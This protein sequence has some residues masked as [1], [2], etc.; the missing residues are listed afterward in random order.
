MVSSSLDQNIKKAFQKD[1]RLT[2]SECSFENHR[3]DEKF[4]YSDT[5]IPNEKI[6][7]MFPKCK[8]RNDQCQY[9]TFRKK[10]QDFSRPTNLTS[11]ESSLTNS[12][13]DK[14]ANSNNNNS[15][16]NNKSLTKIQ[17]PDHKNQQHSHNDKFMERHVKNFGIKMEKNHDYVETNPFRTGNNNQ[18]FC[19]P[20]DT[21]Y[22]N[23]NS[24]LA[25]S[26][27]NRVMDRHHYPPMNDLDYQSA[28]EDRNYFF[29]P[30]EIEHNPYMIHSIG[31]SRKSVH[32]TILNTSP[33]A[34]PLAL[35]VS[36]K[37]TPTETSPLRSNQNTWDLSPIKSTT[38]SLIKAQL[39][40]PN[41]F[42]RSN[43]GSYKRLTSPI[44]VE[45]DLE[46]GHF[47]YN[48]KKN[49]YEETDSDLN[50]L[51]TIQNVHDVDSYKYKSL[52][53]MPETKEQL[54]SN[55]FVYN[56]FKKKEETQIIKSKC[57]SGIMGM[58]SNRN[59][60]L[61]LCNNCFYDFRI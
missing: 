39:S 23:K 4:N 40:S 53:A 58:N 56:D 25:S 9:Q 20:I 46:T 13:I 5:S 57:G 2:D 14:R 45:E 52:P 7:S 49:Y 35:S 51:A 29:E 27:N 34:T 26:N 19:T 36:P 8:P 33:P 38:A 12:A 54:E 42:T 32:S 59:I 18:Y 31:S 15:N 41:L 11:I 6:Q 44:P 3:S 30:D 22:G 50:E 43:K 16:L 28:M 60:L 1:K 55:D 10:Q 47:S 24:T 17:S 61:E 37:T 21:L 48:S